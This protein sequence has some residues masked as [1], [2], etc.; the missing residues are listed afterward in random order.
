MWK[1]GV[2]RTESY[3]ILKKYE[4]AVAL[5][6]KKTLDRGDLVYQNASLL[7]WLRNALIHY[8][9]IRSTSTAESSQAHEESFR[10]SSLESTHWSENTFLSGKV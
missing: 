3:P 5:A 9:P 10:A 2:P 1:L 7:V 8:E 4:I 6:E